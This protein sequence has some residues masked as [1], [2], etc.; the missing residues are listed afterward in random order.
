ML[1]LLPCRRR[2]CEMG[3]TNLSDLA[4]IAIPRCK[5]CTAKGLSRQTL[6]REVL[7]SN[8]VNSTPPPFSSRATSQT[9]R[10]VEGSSRLLREQSN[11]VLAAIAFEGEEEAKA[12]EKRREGRD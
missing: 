6:V 8:K 12:V 9:G 3:R 7:G 4:E 5:L 11:A 2:R 1:R 10:I